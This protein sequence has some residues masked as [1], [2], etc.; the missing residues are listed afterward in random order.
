VSKL[1]TEPAAASQSTSDV[2]NV[3]LGTWAAAWLAQ[4]TRHAIAHWAA[5][6]TAV[7]LS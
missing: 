5:T 6:R 3:M 7:E 4:H 1:T 2:Y